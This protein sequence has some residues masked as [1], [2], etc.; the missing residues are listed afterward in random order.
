MSFLFEE[1]F[2]T[3]V[4]KTAGSKLFKEQLFDNIE[5]STP[6]YNNREQFYKDLIKENIIKTGSFFT[7]ILNQ[8]DKFV[9]TKETRDKFYG[10]LNDLILKKQI[11]ETTYT[12]LK[13]FYDSETST[14][15][16]INN[17]GGNYR[18]NKSRRKNRKQNSKTFNV[19]HKNKNNKKQ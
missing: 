10:I 14:I 13:N 15:G 6:L 9:S 11:N 1:L 4:D 2:F 12:K 19:N 18:K 7:I 8:A 3:T 17:F 16:Q 5:K